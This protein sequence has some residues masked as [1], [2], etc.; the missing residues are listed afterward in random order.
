[1][2][3]LV[4][5]ALL[6]VAS[7][8]VLPPLQQVADTAEVAAAKVR[9]FQL[10]KEQAALA[11]A[12]LDDE[13]SKQQS[14]YT[15]AQAPVNSEGHVVNTEEVQNAINAFNAF[16]QAQLTATAGATQVEAIQ[17]EAA[18]VHQAEHEPQQY[19]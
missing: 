10:Y 5:L 15:G 19:S 18:V 1:M 13:V 3:S 11:K 7:A 6:G 14:Q 9:F 2:N 17:H 8:A 12:A 4:C 16:H